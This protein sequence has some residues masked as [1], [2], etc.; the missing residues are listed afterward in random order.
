MVLV[1]RTAHDVGPTVSAPLICAE[2]SLPACRH[3]AFCPL[4]NWWN[5]RREFW[6]QFL[7][8]IV[9]KLRSESTEAVDAVYCMT[10]H[11]EWWCALTHQLFGN[12]ELFS[13]VLLFFCPAAV[14]GRHNTSTRAGDRFQRTVSFTNWLS[15][16]R[17]IGAWVSQS[18]CAAISS[19]LRPWEGCRCSDLYVSLS[20][21]LL[22]CLKNHTSILNP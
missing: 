8:L 11:C 6:E 7:P 16:V 22:A 20:V 18:L 12:A 4:S 21:C 17:W 3:A 5:I 14:C 19:L 2:W 13:C 10:V 15:I 1:S 9:N